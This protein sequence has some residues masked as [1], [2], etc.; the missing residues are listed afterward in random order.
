MS[1]G[2]SAV[3]MASSWQPIQGGVTAPNG[4]QA[5]GIVAGLK[6]SGKPDLAL[7]LAPVTA[8][9]AGTFTTSVVRAACVDLC[10]DRLAST[11]GQARAVLINS[12]QANACTGDRG[13]VDS[14][15]ATQVLADQLGVDAESV[16]ICS[17]GVIG[18]PIPMPTLLAGLAPLVEA[19]DD[20]GV[21]RRPTPSSPPIWWTSR[22]RL[23]WNWRGAGCASEGWPKARE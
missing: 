8:V 6:P 4:F 15:R 1:R 18:V 2:G 3:A 19:L 22:W 17:T 5:A 20:A 14:Q 16:L 13:L 7:V 11:A 23:N 9:C 12:G 10:R 21:M